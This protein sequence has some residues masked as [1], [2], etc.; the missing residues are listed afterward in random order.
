ML[1]Y[2]STYGVERLLRVLGTTDEG[3]GVGDGLPTGAHCP[4]VRQGY[5]PDVE[6]TEKTR[7]DRA[8]LGAQSISL[9][10]SVDECTGLV[11][12]RL[13]ARNERMTDADLALL[14]EL[15]LPG[16]L[17]GGLADQPGGAPNG[18][19]SPGPSDAACLS[20]RPAR[21][22]RPTAWTSRFART[23]I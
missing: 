23:R 7:Q 11:Y 10:F 18:P 12:E 19:A 5:L 4:F 14:A 15:P 6:S 20:S 2:A 3:D 22:R 1:H 21:P 13:L 9:A 17:A 16:W 8:L